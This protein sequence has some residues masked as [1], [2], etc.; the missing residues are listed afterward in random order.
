M[1]GA[2]S[3]IKR[4]HES[5]T[6]GAALTWIQTPE[7]SDSASASVMVSDPSVRQSER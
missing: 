5:V 4:R 3:T 1:I 2:E 7:D 6:D